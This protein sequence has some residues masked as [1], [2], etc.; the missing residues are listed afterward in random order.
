MIVD[1]VLY[2]EQVMAAGD[3]I[4]I[5]G[6]ESNSPDYIRICDEYDVG[7]EDVERYILD[8]ECSYDWWLTNE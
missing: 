4:R 6:F 8:S 2:E 3:Q 7:V 1:S 5:E